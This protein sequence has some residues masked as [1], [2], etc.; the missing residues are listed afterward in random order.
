MVLTA[1][2]RSDAQF[3][4]RSQVA[5]GSSRRCGHRALVAHGHGCVRLPAT[6]SFSSGRSALSAL[7]QL[8]VRQLTHR[9]PDPRR[10]D[11]RRRRGLASGQGRQHERPGQLGSLALDDPP[12]RPRHLSPSCVERDG[13]S[14]AADACAAETDPSDELLRKY[15]IAVPM[16]PGGQSSRSNS[17]SSARPPSLGMPS[18]SRRGGS[19][20]RSPS[21]ASNLSTTAPIATIV[22]QDDTGH[23]RP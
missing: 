10:L 1:R 19:H 17:V 18:P 22:E 12:L 14:S 16:S 8:S 11:R 5:L 23:L 6:S 2:R 13:L 21:V 7:A 4:F 9:S 20:S 3:V 15:N